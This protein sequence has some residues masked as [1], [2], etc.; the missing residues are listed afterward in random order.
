[1]S[2]ILDL[3]L[4]PTDQGVSVSRFVAPVIAMI[5]ASGY[6][7][8]LSSM[9]T[10][11]ETETLPQALELIDRAHALLEAMGCERIYAVAKLD[12]RRGGQGRLSGK[13]ESVQRHL[14]EARTLDGLSSD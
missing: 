13:L 1:M 9:G 10:Q 8:R 12:S 5:R 6:D 3:A 11:V 2:V 7:Y 4:F 14:G